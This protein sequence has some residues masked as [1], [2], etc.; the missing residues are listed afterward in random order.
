MFKYLKTREYLLELGFFALLTAV[1]HYFALVNFLYWNVDWFDILMHFLGGVTMAYLA[2]F[3]FFTS[4]Y[5][6]VF[7]NLRKNLWV[8][9]FVV[10]LFTAVIGLGWE[11]LEIFSGLSNVL[12]DRFDTILDLVMDML[13]AVAVFLLEVRRN[14]KINKNN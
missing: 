12:T 9:F 3:V 4:R 11:L 8:V 14:K 1:L 7:S 6:P 2:L 5:I 10:M 13:G